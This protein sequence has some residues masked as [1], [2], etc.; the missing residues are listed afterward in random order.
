MSRTDRSGCV[1]GVCIVWRYHS[2][3][4]IHSDVV[5]DLEVVHICEDVC[6]DHLKQIYSCGSYDGVVSISSVNITVPLGGFCGNVFRIT[7]SR[8]GSLV[9]YPLESLVVEIVSGQEMY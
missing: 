5:R 6:I 3:F 2:R 7:A 4:Y 8:S 9:V 1:E